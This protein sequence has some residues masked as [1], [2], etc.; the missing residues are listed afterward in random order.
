MYEPSVNSSPL[1]ESNNRKPFESLTLAEWK[2]SASAEVW[3]P[4]LLANSANKLAIVGWVGLWGLNI[5]C[6]ILFNDPV[7]KALVVI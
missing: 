7:Y 3:Y 5:E 1:S 6:S 2:N 4:Y